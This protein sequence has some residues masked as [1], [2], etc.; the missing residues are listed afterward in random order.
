M[1]GSLRGHA[2]S[3]DPWERGGPPIELGRAYHPAQRCS[4]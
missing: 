4:P 3:P 1:L 2:L